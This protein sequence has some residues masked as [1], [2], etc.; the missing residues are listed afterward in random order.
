MSNA[1][2]MTPANA[3]AKPVGTLDGLL[4]EIREGAGI[5][6]E[7]LSMMERTM[8]VIIDNKAWEVG[9]PVP[10][11]VTQI[12]AYIADDDGEVRIYSV[13]AQNA[14]EVAMRWRRSML[15]SSQSIVSMELFHVLVGREM[16]DAVE[17]ATEVPE[18]EEV[19]DYMRALPP[20]TPASQILA[21]IEAGK[22]QEDDDDDNNN[23]NGAPGAPAVS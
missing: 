6:D 4:D 5:T 9:Q 22:H 16:T 10:V 19:L 12:I 21:D 14:T 13:P 3:Q 11:R 17:A 20:T 7:D 15:R 2:P 1:V 18:L 23:P 8:R